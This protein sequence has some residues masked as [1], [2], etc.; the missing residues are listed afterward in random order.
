MVVVFRDNT[1]IEWHDYLKCAALY[2]LLHVI[3]FGVFYIIKWPLSKMG[4][5]LNWREVTMLAYSGVRGAPALALGEIVALH[6][7]ITH[8][9]K[10]L[11]LFHVSG[12]V[13][14]TLTINCYFSRYVIEWLGLTRM[15]D[16]K[17]KMLRNLIKAYKLEVH[18]T[19]EKMKSKKNFDKVDWDGLKLI[20]GTNKVRDTVF[21]RRKMQANKSDLESSNKFEA[22]DLVFDN[23]EYTNEELY[24]E[25]KHRYL[26]SLK[27]IYWD[28]LEKGRCLPSS[29]LLL[30]ESAAR[31]ID[32][33]SDDI[34]DF[35][36]LESYFTKT[37]F[38]KI[39]I[40]L[41]RTWLIKYFVHNWLFDRL[42]YEYDVTM[43]YIEAHEECL[44]FI[45][46]IVYN[47]DILDRLR[48]EVRNELRK[49][50]TKLYKHIQDN[51]PQVTKAIQFRRGGHYLIH[52]MEKFL[53][54]MVHHGQMEQ[55]EANYFL[56]HLS[57]EEKRL[58]LGNFKYDFGH[59]DEDF[60]THTELS[61][62]FTQAEMESLARQ[63]KSKQFDRGEIILHIDEPIKYLYYV[64]SG[65]VHEKASGILDHNCPRIKHRMGD[66][67]G[68]QHLG[69][70]GGYSYTNIY[71]KSVCA[72][73]E[74]PVAALL[75]MIKTEEQEIKLW[76]YIAPTVF[77]LKPDQFSRFHDLTEDEIKALLE[78][79]IYK[80]YQPGDRI[81]FDTGAILIEGSIEKDSQSKGKDDDMESRYGKY[82]TKSSYCFVFPSNEKFIAQDP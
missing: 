14:L 33:E 80:K 36:F 82:G 30:I 6:D 65:V 4:Y 26:T 78:S 22:K 75:N 79:S 31:A 49:A 63:F 45:D 64:Q 41:Q 76:L 8:R 39:W 5:P 23:N 17:K 12:I 38:D 62:I 40:K 9:E 61:Q 77:K 1:T 20:A 68:L 72:C 53:N 74:I 16:V 43:S 58:I 60:T 71:T 69:K 7:N 2:L 56:H 52:H 57:K 15:P 18:N 42:S 47:D 10:D 32:H 55:K 59:P 44:E 51:F 13:L 27:G 73:F 67:L 29:A 50:E 25:A 34:K 28:F 35:T 70:T 19:I 3:R 24:I 54:D 46:Q 81:N 66:L 21:K 48:K 37:W 11:I